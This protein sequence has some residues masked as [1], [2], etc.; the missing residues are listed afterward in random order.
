MAIDTLDEVF[1]DLNVGGIG[2]T[3][4]ESSACE[5]VKSEFFHGCECVVSAGSLPMKKV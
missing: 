5:N 1:V 2:R 4:K 3:A